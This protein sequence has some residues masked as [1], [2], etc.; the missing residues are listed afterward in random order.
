MELWHNVCNYNSNKTREPENELM[1]KNI[2][3][4]ATC[5][6]LFLFSGLVVLARAH[7]DQDVEQREEL[8]AEARS[9]F[10]R[11]KL[12]SNQKIVGKITSINGSV[13]KVEGFS[14]QSVG[15]MV[16]VSEELNIIGEIIK[17]IDNII[18][19]KPRNEKEIESI[20]SDSDKGLKRIY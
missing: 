20:L 3:F 10:M 7:Q 4:V 2:F 11:G 8:D 6:F 18:S 13:I 1:K 14:Y 17:I 16:N 9:Q 15:D 12:L 5:S 19:N